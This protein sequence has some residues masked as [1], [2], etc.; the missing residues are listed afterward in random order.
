MPLLG[1]LPYDWYVGPTRLPRRPG[2]PVRH[3][4]P[5]RGDDHASPYSSVVIV[6]GPGDQRAG[7]ISIRYPRVRQG[8]PNL[9]GCGRLRRPRL[10][11][12]GAAA[13]AGQ[14]RVVA[15]CFWSQR[16][17]GGSGRT[18][19]RRRGKST[20]ASPEGRP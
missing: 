12:V 1:R 18:S 8:R 19:R 20:G 16:A 2:R 4:R 5:G 6:P 9:A 7:P 15:D 13:P 11:P 17:A 10:A 3:P 14:R